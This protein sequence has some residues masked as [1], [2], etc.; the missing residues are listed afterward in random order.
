MK[1]KPER[2]RVIFSLA[3]LGMVSAM[4]IPCASPALGSEPLGDLE[5]RLTLVD[6]ATT[7]DSDG[8][9]A[10]G[11]A[12]VEAIL[13]AAAP[14]REVRL[15]VLRPDGAAWTADGRP[16]DPGPAAWT[17]MDGADALV[18]ADG[19]VTIGAREAVRT[20]LEVPLEG[21]A[22]HEIVVEVAGRG[23]RGLL[24]TESALRVVLGVPE[25]HE[26]DD[27]GYVSFPVEVRP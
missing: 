27:D 7:T 12:R 2:E 10:G 15:R 4:A 21:A 5:L 18:A 6:L 19:S 14:A 8:G 13:Q 23:A 11:V 17:R 26:E 1:R 9:V 3:L 22:V 20:V 25:S 24:R 16:F